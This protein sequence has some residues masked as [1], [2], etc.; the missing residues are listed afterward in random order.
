[1]PEAKIIHVSRDPM[2]T[3]WSNFKQYFAAAGMGYS[4]D[5]DDVAAFY[6]LYED[7]MAFWRERF[8]DAIYELDY[9]H[10]TEN[11]EE[12]TRKLVAWCGLEWEDQCLDFHKTDRAVS[13]ASALQVR[14]AMY[15]GSSA[16][17]TK[18]EAHL[19]A[20]KQSLAAEAGSAEQS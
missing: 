10:L 8:G 20:L 13:T 14:E 3:C 4:F 1:M 18:F 17:W 16:N 11:Q 2:A 6:K 9:E 7:I 5:L 12:E 15:Q 19:G